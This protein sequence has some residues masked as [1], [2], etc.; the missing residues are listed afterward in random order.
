[1][2]LSSEAIKASSCNAL[3]FGSGENGAQELGGGRRER[4]Q[5]GTR[6]G[7]RDGQCNSDALSEQA[8][9]GTD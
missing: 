3:A 8:G 7:G 2:R 6:A 9:R 1:M 4:R 5:E